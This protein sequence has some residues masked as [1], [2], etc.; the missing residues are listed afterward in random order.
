MHSLSLRYATLA[1]LDLM[2]ALEESSFSYDQIGR[3]SF[4]HLLQSPTAQVYV[5]TDAQ[6][7]IAYAII[8][9]RRN[10]RY[11]R[12]YSMAINATARSKGVGSWLLTQVIEAL[13]TQYHGMR[14][15]VKTNN[16]AGLSLY[17]RLGFEVVDVLP[18][19]YSDG[20]AGYRM[21]LTWQDLD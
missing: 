9:T 6:H 8:L 19:Y 2:C 10:S 1:D 12:L 17:Y 21:Q 14:L 18:D 15:E 7:I 4:R 20:D 16:A 11:C 13:K 5:C 3:R